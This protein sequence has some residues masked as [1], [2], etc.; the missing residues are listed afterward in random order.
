VVPPAP[1]VRTFG[2]WR[3]FGYTLA[4][5]LF[6]SILQVV[7]GLIVLLVAM[8]AGML[9]GH[10]LDLSKHTGPGGLPAG[11]PLG[12]ILGGGTVLAAPFTTWLTVW[13]ARRRL[14]DREALRDFFGLRRAGFRQSLLWT[15][16]LVVFAFG[17][18]S[19]ASYLD[20]PE[21]P[22]F[23]RDILQGPSAYLPLLWLA[24]VVAAPILEEI[25][26]RGFLFGGLRSSRLGPWGALAV[27]S[28]CFAVIHTQYDWF[29]MSAVLVLGVVLGLA[30]HFSGSVYL[31]M[32]L[33]ALHNFAS[34]LFT[35]LYLQKGG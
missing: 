13:L 9:T 11:L 23:M 10:P 1:P 29:D 7:A 33:H 14:P 22:P 2:P 24:V 31:P 27:T 5:F 32:G 34:M 8:V 12:L 17:F 3:V 28:L 26:F 21:I 35:T 6:Y 4:I 25:L 30:R 15:L 16:A 19:L 18:E 20:R